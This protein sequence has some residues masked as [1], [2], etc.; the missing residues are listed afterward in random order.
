MVI[1]VH[2]YYEDNHVDK[3]HKDLLRNTKTLQEAQRPTCESIF[4]TKTYLHIHLFI[5]N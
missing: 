4:S 3:K 2:I 1:C 5:N